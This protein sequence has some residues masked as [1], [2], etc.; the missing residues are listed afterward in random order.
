[1]TGTSRL[2]NSAVIADPL[3]VRVRT[4][5][6]D[7]L[8]A[9]IQHLGGILASLRGFQERRICSCA[10]RDMFTVIDTA[11]VGNLP[12]SVANNSLLIADPYCRIEDATRAKGEGYGDTT[13]GRRRP[14]VFGG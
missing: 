9:C 11:L 7:L 10:I 6:L 4:P 12:L 1:M 8:Q 2:T 13:H 14:S 5:V 3:P